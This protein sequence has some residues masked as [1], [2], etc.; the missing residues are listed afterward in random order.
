MRDGLIASNPVKGIER[1]HEEKRDRFL[2]KQEITQFEQ[3]LEDH[4]VKH[5]GTRHETDA[6]NAVNALTLLLL[7]GARMSEV[8]KLSWEQLD[9][10]RGEWTKPSHHTKQKKTEHVP[11]S[12]QALELLESL[13][14]QHARGPLFIGRDG[15][16]ARVSIRRPWLA[17]CKA[18]GLVTVEVVKGRRR[19]AVTKYKPTVRIHDLRHT[20]ASHLASMGYSLQIIG[21]LIGHTQAATTLRYAHLQDDALRAATDQFS[22]VIEFRKRA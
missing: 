22:K 11:L 9:L 3:A 10:D 16:A 7:T 5:Q 4:V 15:K 21:R 18:A 2:S 12:A 1:Y 19:H 14:P 8:L 6:Q 20:F 17:A 13:K